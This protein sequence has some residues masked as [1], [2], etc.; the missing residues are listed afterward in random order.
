MSLV[1]GHCLVMA[2]KAGRCVGTSEGQHLTEASSPLIDTVNLFLA[3]FPVLF[4]GLI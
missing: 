1:Q 4:V 2:G 3:Q